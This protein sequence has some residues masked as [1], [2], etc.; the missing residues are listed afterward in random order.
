MSCCAYV[1]DLAAT[2]WTDIGEP[3][4]MTVGAIAEQMTSDQYLGLLSNLIGQCYSSDDQGC[5][6]PALSP[7]E[8]SILAEIFKV[9]YY[10]R[11]VVRQTGAGGAERVLAEIVEADTRIRWTSNAELGK[12]L[13][14]MQKD[15]QSRL[16]ALIRSYLDFS[17]GSNIPR[18]VNYLEII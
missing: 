12:I 17:K 16:D 13:V 3:T 8:Q 1:Q 11:L 10:G 6:V 14:Q 5:I 9:N 18:S 2:I 4:S 15:A 7:T